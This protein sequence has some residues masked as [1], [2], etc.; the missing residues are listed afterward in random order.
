MFFSVGS[1][2]V[3]QT[4]LTLSHIFFMIQVT[5]S[6]KSQSF[7]IALRHKSSVGAESQIVDVKNSPGGV[8]WLI[9]SAVLLFPNHQPRLLHREIV[10]VSEHICQAALWGALEA[11]LLN[12]AGVI[13]NNNAECVTLTTE[14]CSAHR[15]QIWSWSPAICHSERLPKGKL[16]SSQ[17]ALVQSKIHL[18]GDMLVMCPS[19]A[20]AAGWRW[21]LVIGPALMIPIWWKG[22]ETLQANSANHYQQRL[23]SSLRLSP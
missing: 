4:D 7:S 15:H 14:G 22:P 21:T 23:P 5:K 1:E 2:S 10:F 17:D 6:P 18:H 11:A 20:S 16:P 19:L 3:S 13:R 9:G 12:R 8:K